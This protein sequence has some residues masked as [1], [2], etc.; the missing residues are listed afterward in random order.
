MA[1]ISQPV[2]LPV[3]MGGT[4]TNFIPLNG[5]VVGQGFNTIGAIPPGPT[6]TVLISTGT[7][8]AYSLV[9]TVGSDIYLSNNFGGF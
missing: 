8:W 1:Y 2:P 4:G 5:I 7:G 9:Y 6:G 3:T